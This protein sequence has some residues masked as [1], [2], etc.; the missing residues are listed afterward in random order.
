MNEKKKNI[1]DDSKTIIDFLI[2]SARRYAELDC[3]RYLKRGEY[4][5]ITWEEVMEV[6]KLFTLGLKSLGIERQD[7]V[8]LMSKTRYEWRLVDY[9]I[10]FSGATT[11]TLYPSLTSTQ[12]EYILNDSNSK[13]VVVDRRRNL[14]KVLKVQPNCPS[15]RHVISIE[16]LPPELKTPTVIDLDGLI[17]KGLAYSEKHPVDVPAD[18]QKTLSKAT[19]TLLKTHNI[20][21]IEKSLAALREVDDALARL[22]DPFVN[23]YKAVR[24]EDIATIVYT[25]GTTGVPKGALLTHRNMAV[26]AMQTTQVI[27]I[28]QHDVALSF[29]P[30]SHVL[31]RQVGH[32][33]ATLV[34][35]TIA[36]ARDT[37]SLIENLD[38]VKPTFITSVPRIYEKLYDRI[39]ADVL[40]GSEAKEKIFD[41]AVEWGYE[42]NTKI[43]EGED[44][45][46]GIAMKNWLA[47]TLVF[48][49]I[50]KI[51]GGRLRFMFSGGAALNPVLARF[52]FSAGF[53]IMEGYGLTETSPVL[54]INPLEKILFGTVGPAV[55]ETE[56]K[57]AGDGEIICKGPQ[58]FQGYWNK[59]D[60][61][62]SAF[63]EE[64]YYHT[65]DLGEFTSEGYLKITGRK[66]TVIVLRTGKKVSPV[67]TEAAI[68]LDRHIAHACVIGDDMKYLVAVIEPN[69]EYLAEWM[70]E[71]NLSPWKW[72][73]LELYKGM[74]KEEFEDKMARRKKIIEIPEVMAFYTQL[75]EELQQSLSSFER[76]KRFTLVAD[77]WTEYNVL[78]PSMK[79]KRAK[80]RETYKHLIDQIYVE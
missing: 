80:I 46:V 10:L 34:G 27:P 53:K 15:I 19:K 45:G 26:N 37:D 59:P 4:V 7:R 25:S 75:I 43:Q 47:S 72:E 41:K 30:L 31:E 35:Y 48:H 49:K 13:I 14:E 63:D 64:G 56:I 68:A 9:G 17:E 60:E 76:V 23:T 24:P 66:K 18:I 5:G 40:S 69:F 67:V 71:K 28:K 44:V 11:V 55:P 42:Y 58:V 70:E 57:I 74:G 21:K 51:L 73:D 3:M 36:Y 50:E 12:V 32:F 38:Q 62:A 33:L 6:T 1:I 52:F 29:L 54:S 39:I 77:E 78:T 22:E 61:N 2:D 79:M 20:Q 8:A 16:R 65:G